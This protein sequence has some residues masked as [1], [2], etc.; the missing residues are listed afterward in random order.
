MYYDFLLG[1]LV[2]GNPFFQDQLDSEIETAYNNQVA[3]VSQVDAEAGT[4]TTVNRWTAE[5][6]KQAITALATF[7]NERFVTGNVT[8][9]S[10]NDCLNI[11]GNCDITLPTTFSIGDSFE[12][13]DVDLA[14]AD[15]DVK[16]LS[17]SGIFINNIEI[18][19]FQFDISN[20]D[21]QVKLVAINKWRVI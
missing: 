21:A 20:V 4:S 15:N 6:V 5:R 10:K 19:N 16:I 8:A 18:E 11:S 14:F 13:A 3:V 17:G 7:I 1:R 2:A 12:I 9:V